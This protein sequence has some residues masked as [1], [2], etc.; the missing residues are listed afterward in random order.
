MKEDYENNNDSVKIFMELI[1]SGQKEIYAYIISLLISPS[2]ADDILQETL[3][4]MWRKFGEFER[5]T[6]F[7]AWGK[8]IARYKIMSHLQK[9]RSSGLCFDSDI[10]KLIESK[11]SQIE[12]L[13]DRNEALKKCLQKLPEKHRSMLKMRYSQDMSFK[14]M[15]LVFGVAKQ[16][17]YRM[18]SRIHALLASCIKSTLATGGEYGI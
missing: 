16:S 4:V 7:V 11:S 18:V 6:N 10:L 1:L 3:T 2:D 9:N 13:S 14:Q 8:Q 12:N 5:G 15:A 17:V